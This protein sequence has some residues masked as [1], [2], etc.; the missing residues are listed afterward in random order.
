MEHEWEIDKDSCLL[1]EHTT[2]HILI[3]DIWKLKLC[4]NCLP[5][6]YCVWHY[7]LMYAIANYCIYQWGTLVSYSPNPW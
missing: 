6:W 1:S 7:K 5:T 2:Y 3:Y 4:L